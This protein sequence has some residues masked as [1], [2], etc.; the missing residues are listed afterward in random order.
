MSSSLPI[1]DTMPSVM[2]TAEASG[3]PGDSVVILPL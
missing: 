2:A 1:A 3:F